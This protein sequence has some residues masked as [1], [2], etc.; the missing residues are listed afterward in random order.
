MSHTPI[1]LIENVCMDF[2][3][4][5]IKLNVKTCCLFEQMTGKSFLAISDLD[6]ILHLMYASLV[7]N[8]ES[9]FMTYSVFTKLVQDPKVAKWIE[10]EYKKIQDYNSQ[11]GFYEE[12]K[13]TEEKK[14]ENSEIRKISE[15]AANLIVQ[16]GMDAH[17]VM[18]EMELWELAMYVKSYDEKIKNEMVDKRFWTYLQI[19]PQVDGKK[20][21]SPS[22]LVP[23]A[24]EA[25]ERKKKIEQD[26]KNNMV[27]IKANIG[28]VLD[29]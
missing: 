28:R 5:R 4:Y 27:A 29:I 19:L 12:K 3:N 2:K 7:V 14:E 20:I 25:E 11:I 17:Y 23:F 22:H 16:T 24:W 18:Y 13:E 1:S 21:K 9:L 6:D 26:I 10:T 8:N 15:I